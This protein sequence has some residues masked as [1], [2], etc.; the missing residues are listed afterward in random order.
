MLDYILLVSYGKAGLV[1]VTTEMES[2]T[3]EG[4][5][6]VVVEM[7]VELIGLERV[8]DSEVEVEDYNYEYDY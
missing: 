6:A 8:K 4:L 2:E 5:V 1:V 7:V 3:E